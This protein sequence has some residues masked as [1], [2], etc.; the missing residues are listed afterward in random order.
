M[1]SPEIL[2]TPTEFKDKIVSGIRNAKSHIALASLYL[3]DSRILSSLESSLENNKSLQVTLI[4]DKLRST[5]KSTPLFLYKKLLEKYNPRFSVYLYESPLLP[6]FMRNI[7]RFNE[8]FGL[9]HI[10]AYIFDQAVLLSGYIH[11]I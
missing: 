3:D 2:E 6:Y 9:M 1:H 4:F 8:A 5:R 10:K 7:P 11:L